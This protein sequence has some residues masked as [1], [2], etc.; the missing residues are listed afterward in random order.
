MPLHLQP[1]LLLMMM[2]QMWLKAVHYLN[3]TH[4]PKGLLTL[5][6]QAP[7]S[8][9]AMN[10]KTPMAAAAATNRKNAIAQWVLTLCSQFVRWPRPSAAAHNSLP[11]A[12]Y[13]SFCCITSTALQACPLCAE[14]HQTYPRST[15]YVM[16]LQAT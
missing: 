8:C 15:S 16:K 1:L 5:A 3:H 13:V 11:T 7:P 9:L 6:L 10:V 2:M 4:K 12:F 14:T